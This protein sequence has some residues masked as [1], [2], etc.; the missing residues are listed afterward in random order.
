MSGVDSLRQNKIYARPDIYKTK[1]NNF[2]L[3]VLTIYN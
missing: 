1:P 3:Q 2:K